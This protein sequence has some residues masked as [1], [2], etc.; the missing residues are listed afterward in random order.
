[1]ETTEEQWYKWNIFQKLMSDI[2]H[3]LF[4]TENQPTIFNKKNKQK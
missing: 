3:S 2:W 1:M 4:L